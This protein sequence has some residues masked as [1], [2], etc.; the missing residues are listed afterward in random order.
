MAETAAALARHQ[1]RVAITALHGMRG[2]GKT[3]PAVAYAERHRHDYRATWWVRSE[4]EDT[5]RADLA[6]LGYRLGWAG[7]DDSEQDAL[8]KVA[9]RLRQENEGILL[10]FDNALDQRL[11]CALP[12]RSAG[13]RMS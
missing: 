8:A 13:P 6:A 11:D 4:T 10:I 12:A 2:V 7:A 5:M 3:M 9:D 1:G